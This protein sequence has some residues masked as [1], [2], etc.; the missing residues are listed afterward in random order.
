MTVNASGDIT[1]IDIIINDNYY[2]AQ[3]SNLSNPPIWTVPAKADVLAV[4]DNQGTQNHNWAVLKKDASISVPFTE[5]QSSHL[6]EYGAGMIY[7]QNQTTITFTAPEE[8]GEYLVIC[9]VP[10]HYPS[11]QGRLVVE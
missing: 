5:G 11:M 3:N 10:G 6:I 2:G 4:V 8:I 9:T 7:G 1:S